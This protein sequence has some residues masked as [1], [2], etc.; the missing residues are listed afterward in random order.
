MII[1]CANLSKWKF[2]RYYWCDFSVKITR[3]VTCCIPFLSRNSLKHGVF[4][5]QC[6]WDWGRKDS[7]GTNNFFLL[8]VQGTWRLGSARLLR[9]WGV[10]LEGPLVPP[11]GGSLW[12]VQSL[13][14]SASPPSSGAKIAQGTLA[15]R[16]HRWGPGL[17][18]HSHLSN[19]APM[20]WQVQSSSLMTQRWLCRKGGQELILKSLK[21]PYAVH[22]WLVLNPYL[23]L[24]S[25][26][27]IHTQAF[28]M[29]PTLLCS[30][31]LIHAG[32][33]ANSDYLLKPTLFPSPAGVCIFI[34]LLL[35]Q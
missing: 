31:C 12:L 18:T 32:T 3:S 11:M 1:K 2:L 17:A 30:G 7:W 6:T 5:S 4:H 14:S 8:V 25:H 35:L 29:P 20:T 15:C 19:Q 21:L 34:K 27:H 24:G 9:M 13:A 33:C 28:A 10:K 23:R 16:Q 22:T 26:T